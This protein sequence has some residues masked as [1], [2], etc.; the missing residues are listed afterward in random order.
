MIN[1]GKPSEK[2]LVKFDEM[3]SG[4]KSIPWLVGECLHDEQSSDKQL[5][6]DFLLAIADL[7][8]GTSV[9]V[10]ATD[11]TGA[12]TGSAAGMSLCF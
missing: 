5:K 2:A 9:T 4:A 1:Q 3:D 11:S 10:M 6:K 12:T 8:A 7:A